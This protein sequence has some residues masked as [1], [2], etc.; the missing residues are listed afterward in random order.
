MQ[1]Y[2]KNDIKQVSVEKYCL[3]NYFKYRVNKKCINIKKGTCPSRVSA[4]IN[5][6]FYPLVETYKVL[7]IFIM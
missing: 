1:S 2:A 4:L 7:N 3:F 6:R 5:L